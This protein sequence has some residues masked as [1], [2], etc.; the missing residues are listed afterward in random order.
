MT[1]Q[2]IRFFYL[3]TLAF[4]VSISGVLSFFL[5]FVLNLFETEADT[6][7][8]DIFFFLIQQLILFAFL[9]GVFRIKNNEKILVK[10]FYF[11][12]LPTIPIV[13]FSIINYLDYYMLGEVTRPSVMT[14][15]GSIVFFLSI[16]YNYVKINK[17]YK[18]PITDN[19]RVLD[20]PIDNNTSVKN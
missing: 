4:S 17:T 11:F 13:L 19:E 9:S 18:L 6:T 8:A 5:F 15:I 7:E 2:Q 12:I 14:N 16:V 3:K 20:Q 1:K 10:I